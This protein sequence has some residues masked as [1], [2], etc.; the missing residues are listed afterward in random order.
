MEKRDRY[1][2]PPPQRQGTLERKK[3]KQ[4]QKQEK[5]L[6][7]SNAPEDVKYGRSGLQFVDSHDY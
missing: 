4:K 5:E 2:T 3:S 6:K 1:T 7:V